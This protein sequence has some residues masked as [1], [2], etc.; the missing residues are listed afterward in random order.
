MEGAQG[1]AEDLITAKDRAN[2]A[3]ECTCLC[4]CCCCCCTIPVEVPGCPED[5]QIRFQLQQLLMEFG[6]LFLRGGQPA[7]QSR[8]LA[9]MA[10]P[11]GLSL[12]PARLFT[13]GFLGLQ[14]IQGGLQSA[15]LVGRVFLGLE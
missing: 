10:R 2:V 12:G 3:W 5:P 9:A 8:D 15:A 13:D 11:L 4:R 14:V 1:P 7:F 6:S